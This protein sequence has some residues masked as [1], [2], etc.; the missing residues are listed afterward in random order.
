VR[1]RDSLA[2]FEDKPLFGRT[3]V[4]TRQR[5][6]AAALVEPLLE[7]GAEVLEYPTIQTC[8]PEDW[9]PLD[10]AIE[11]MASYD[12]VILSSVNAVESFF[13]R[14]AAHHLDARVL[15]HAQVAA[16]GTATA[17]RCID[18]GVYPDFVPEYFRAEGLL[19]GLLERGVSAGDRIL[20]PRALEAREMLPDSLRRSGAVV[21]VVPVYRTVLGPGEAGVLERIEEGTV[22][23][24][25]FTSGST[26]KNFVQLTSDFDLDVA[27]EQVAAASIGPV[28]TNTAEE[29]G[30]PVT[31]EPAESTIPALVAAIR[32]HLA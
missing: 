18:R 30:I 21:D 25:V 8:D 26:V 12:W 32:E 13:D 15:A 27:F 3:V 24:I 7:L 23:V 22:D 20:I 9:I 1:L 2:W 29:L 31:V 19:D 10:T 6:Q 11:N 28:T 4:V 17:G 5:A 16:V 14:L